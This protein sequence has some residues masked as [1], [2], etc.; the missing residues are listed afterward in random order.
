MFENNLKL[1]QFSSARSSD[2]TET[3]LNIS[4]QQLRADLGVSKNTNIH[5]VMFKNTSTV[6]I[7]MKQCKNWA[8]L[9]SARA[10]KK[11]TKMHTFFA[12]AIDSRDL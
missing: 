5:E 8:I 12:I 7:L 11:R 10:I 1:G 9:I 6:A 3:F 4:S 2:Q